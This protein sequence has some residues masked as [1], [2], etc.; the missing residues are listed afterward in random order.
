MKKSFLYNFLFEDK[1]VKDKDATE[2]E[3]SVDFNGVKAGRQSK[4]SI[5]D[6]IDALIIKYENDSILDDDDSLMESILKKNLRYLLFEQDEDPI[7]DEAPA[8]GEEDTSEPD[9]TGSEDIS[10]KASGAKEEVPN[11]DIDKF[12]KRCARLISNYRNLLRVEEAIVNRIKNYLD[13]YYGD[14]YVTD[15]LEILENQYGMSIEEFNDEMMN[16]KN[17]DMPF[18][19]GANASGTSS[20]GG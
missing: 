14:A 5:D 9:P 8:E 6:Q 7:E 20:G 11:L 15:F 1:D 16:S 3:V 18:A 13:E 2:G 4:D 12:T 17:P 10:K 19:V